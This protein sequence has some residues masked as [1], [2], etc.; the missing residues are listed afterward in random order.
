MA[1]PVSGGGPIDPHRLS[2]DSA[3]S[4][5]GTGDSKLA[6]QAPPTASAAPPSLLGP[7]AEQRPAR[8]IVQPAVR[9]DLTAGVLIRRPS[10]DRPHTSASDSRAPT[11]D[12]VMQHALDLPPERSTAFLKQ[13]LEEPGRDEKTMLALVQSVLAYANNQRDPYRAD[14]LT[15]VAL[16]LPDVP[17]ENRYSLFTTLADRAEQTDAAQLN[18]L[19]VALVAARGYIGLNKQGDDAFGRAYSLI[20][21]LDMSDRSE[22][23]CLLARHGHLLTDD[24]SWPAFQAIIGMPVGDGAAITACAKNAVV[25]VPES[26]RV[27]AFDL[28]FN[29]ARSHPEEFANTLRHLGTFVGCLPKQFQQ[30]KFDQVEKELPG[31]LLSDSAH[32]AIGLLHPIAYQFEPAIAAD[33]FERIAAHLEY[34]D[35]KDDQL[36]AVIVLQECRDKL[37]YGSSQQWHAALLAAQIDE[38]LNASLAG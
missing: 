16:R 3:L 11:L 12:A 6:N 13:I 24:A 32:A 18:P 4:A 21:K 9:R 25:W 37:P 7:L 28:A 15:S 27:E 26:N 19:V 31:L 38:Q 5:D 8:A 23:L 10:R 29:A 14:L 30:R 33:A 1:I 17:E 35:G 20:G 22:P 2:S 36:A 34:V